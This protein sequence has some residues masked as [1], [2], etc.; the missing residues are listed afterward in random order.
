[1][2]MLTSSLMEQ[3]GN[4]E[5]LVLIQTLVIGMNK[6]KGFTLI[7]M[8]I[9]IVIIGITIGFALLS[10]GDFGASK[11]ILFAAEQLEHTLTLAQQQALLENTTLGLRIDNNSYQILKF[12]ESSN[13][14]PISDKG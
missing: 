13:W 3:M 10:F 11:G 9:V 12:D 6:S 2:E 1:M 5:A 7:E 8:L 4:P 14:K